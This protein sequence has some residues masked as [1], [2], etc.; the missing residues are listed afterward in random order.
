MFFKNELHLCKVSAR[1]FNKL[2]FSIA[3]I[4]SWYEH[5]KYKY[6]LYKLLGERFCRE[7]EMRENLSA[8]SFS[9]NLNK[10]KTNSLTL[11]LDRRRGY[12]NQ[13]SVIEQF[14]I[15]CL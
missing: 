13:R 12:S 9:K 7:L 1:F 4:S 8:T 10:K 6:C 3:P 14:L 2:Y 15:N 11:T 5:C